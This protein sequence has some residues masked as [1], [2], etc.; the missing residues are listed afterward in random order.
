MAIPSAPD[1]LDMATLPRG[2]NTG[3]NVPSRR[4]AGS[5]LSTPMQL[6]P[7]M[8]IP[9]RR[10]ASTTFRSSATPLSPISEKPAEITTTPRTPFSAHSFTTSSTWLP[11]T[12]MKARSTVSGIS[13]TE[14]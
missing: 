14:W 2:G 11:G 1:W 9:A 5:V 7:T 8:R 4:T 6:G 10:T 3:A 12:T 13:S